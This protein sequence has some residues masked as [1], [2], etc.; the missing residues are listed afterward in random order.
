MY[1]YKHIFELLTILVSYIDSSLAIA[2]VVIPTSHTYL[3]QVQS[4]ERGDA[5]HLHPY[6]V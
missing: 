1:T 6:T 2:L 3:I 5:K 4:F